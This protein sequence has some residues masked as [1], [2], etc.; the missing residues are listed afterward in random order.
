MIELHQELLDILVCPQNKMR[1]SLA[2]QSLVDQINEGC[3]KKIDGGLIREDRTILYP[4]V[5]GIPIMLID[6]A[7][8]LEGCLYVQRIKVK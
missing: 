3:E 7:I 1:V 5:D 6:E 2:D 4:I 8:S